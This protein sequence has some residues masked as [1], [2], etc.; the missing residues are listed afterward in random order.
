M[1]DSAL[2]ARPTPHG[3]R[4]L[5]AGL[6]TAVL[7][8][9]LVLTDASRGEADS[10]SP[11]FTAAGS[12]GIVDEADQGAVKFT[13]AKASVKGSAVGQNGTVVLRYNVV[14]TEDIEG[15]PYLGASFN[16]EGSN[17][18]IVAKLKLLSQ[19]TGTTETLLTLDSNSSPTGYQTA[20]VSDCNLSYFSF[21]TNAYFVEVRLERSN[22]DNNVQIAGLRVD[23]NP[24]T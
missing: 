24:C 3:W 18:N 20:A 19:T 9:A 21:A 14:A 5:V 15:S 4:W 11:I 17:G 22:L 12:T 10:H 6:L 13:G 1:Q 23:G 8:A 16:D 7:A 2:M